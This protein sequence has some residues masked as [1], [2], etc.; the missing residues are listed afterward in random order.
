MLFAER[1]QTEGINLFIFIYNLGVM[2]IIIVFHILVSHRNPI[3]P[4]GAHCA[5]ADFN[6]L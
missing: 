5:R 2:M 1:K 6:E 4:G 3:Q